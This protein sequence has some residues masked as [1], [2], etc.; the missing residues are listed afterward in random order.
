MEKKIEQVEAARSKARKKAEAKA[1][2][3][4]E[5]AKVK[6]IRNPAEVTGALNVNQLNDQLDIYRALVEDVP[7]KSHMKNKQERI[8][9]LKEAIERYNQSHSDSTVEEEEGEG[10][11]EE[12]ESGESEEDEEENA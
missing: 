3:A 11:G 6:R 9:R 10:E 4:A 12:G 8:E 7:L 1:A 2:K 5:L